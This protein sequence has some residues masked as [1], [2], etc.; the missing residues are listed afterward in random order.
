MNTSK[1]KQKAIRLGIAAVLA[2]VLLVSVSVVLV[3]AN[4]PDEVQADAMTVTLDG[5]V[6]LIFKFND[7]KVNDGTVSYTAVIGEG[8]SERS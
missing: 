6:N 8:E 2:L 7:G 1:R 4:A 5:K 3:I